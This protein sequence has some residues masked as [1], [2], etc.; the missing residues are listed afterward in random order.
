MMLP[1]NQLSTLFSLSGMKFPLKLSNQRGLGGGGVWGQHIRVFWVEI[2]MR[3]MM[4]VGFFAS[5]FGREKRIIK[6]R[7]FKTF[8]LDCGRFLYDDLR[9]NYV[10]VWN[11]S[12]AMLRC[13]K[14]FKWIIEI[15][16]LSLRREQNLCDDFES[17]LYPLK[18]EL[19][20]QI[21]MLIS[22]SNHTCS[23][24]C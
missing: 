7:M 23:S 13:G 21:F 19:L 24:K 10:F 14:S 22:S 20:F 11:P 17:I 12:D 3:D 6:D 1:K 15:G 2:F 8:S 18:H 4:W 9:W 16:S 5:T